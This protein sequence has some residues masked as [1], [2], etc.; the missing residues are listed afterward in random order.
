M[1]QLCWDAQGAPWFGASNLARPTASTPWDM[2]AYVLGGQSSQ[3]SKPN[4]PTNLT[5]TVQ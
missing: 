1:L 2:G 5:A 4:P 3:S